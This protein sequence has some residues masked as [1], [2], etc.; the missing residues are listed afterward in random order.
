MTFQVPQDFKNLQKCGQQR[1][2]PPEIKVTVGL[3]T[4]GIAK[5][6]DTVY[7]AF[8][9]EVKKQKLNATVAPVGCGGC[10]SSEPIVNII[11]P[12][13]TKLTLGE[14]A[15]ADVAAIVKQLKLK[16]VPDIRVLY[17]T[18]AEKNIVE[19]KIQK[20]AVGQ[21]PASLRKV[22]LYE[23]LARFKKQNRIALRNCGIINPSVIEEYV[24][25]GGFKAAYQALSSMKPQKII[26]EIQ[27]SGLRGR[28]GAGF[29]TGNKWQIARETDG[30]P[31]YIICNADEGDPGAYMDRSIMEGDPYSVLEG[32]LIAAYAIGASEGYIYV[33]GEYPLAVTQITAAVAASKKK[34]FL[35]KNIFGTDFN[36]KV[37][38]EKG[39]GA[40]V[41]G[42]E[43]A[44]IASIEG[45]AGDPVPR[46][47]YPVEK[48][49]WGMPTCINNVETLANV[50]VILSRGAKWFAR[51]GNGKSTGTKIFSL[52]GAV[53]RVGLIEVPMGTGLN[54]IIYDIGGG[55]AHGRKLKAVQTG[56]PSGGCV[57]KQYIDIDVDYESLTKAGS[58]MGSGG[59]IVMDERTCMVDVAKYFMSFLKDESCGKCLPCREGTQALFEILDGITDGKGRLKDLEQLKNVCEAMSQA[60]LCS[61]GKTASNPVLSTLRY[62]RK[63]YEAHIKNRTCPAGVCAALLRFSINPEKCIGCG[64]CKKA[65]PVNA[66]TG[67]IK[68]SHKIS[69]KK[70]IA[71]RACHEIC[72]VEAV[73]IR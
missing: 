43:T 57:P 46:P 11:I 36:F 29:P 58:I 4:C 34:G 54:E 62:F 53:E 69:L 39:A 60:S 44:L 5:G 10:C 40:F 47:P 68:K 3:A 1:L 13:M 12:K 49:L 30:E 56:G 16:Q 59:M 45:F 23:S 72:P 32:M 26:K 52:V 27:R 66:V 38:V 67:T 42:E 8:L 63:E 25:L 17:R 21:Q 18:D 2:F 65:C 6:A 7:A 55:I 15:P 37:H 64:A 20:Y 24:A 31:K 70:C 22:P 73:T 41:C 61:L 19:N 9:K 50:P 28:G 71:C 33:R 14:V 48:G 35:G 51:I